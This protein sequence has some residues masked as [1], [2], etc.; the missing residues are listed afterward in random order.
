[1]DDLLLSPFRSLIRCS[2]WPSSSWSS[3]QLPEW[4]PS[5]ANP[6]PTCRWWKPA[7]GSSFLAR[8]GLIPL[9]TQQG[10]HSL[11][12]LAFVAFLGSCAPTPYLVA[13]P[14]V[15]D[16]LWSPACG[17][18]PLPSLPLGPCAWCSFHMEYYSRHL[19]CTTTAPF[20]RSCFS[21]RSQL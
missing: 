18:F 20:G 15:M 16:F 19:T 8:Q 10:E 21:S 14:A 9:L 7:S 3:T 4:L 1:M 17:M 12:D 11:P 2:T 6:I 5:R 13:A